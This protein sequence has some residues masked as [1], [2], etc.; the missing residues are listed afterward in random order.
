MRTSDARRGMVLVVV[1]WTIALLAGLAMAA[2]TTFRGFAGIVGVDRDRI[3]ADALLTAGVERVAGLLAASPNQAVDGEEL[4]ITLSAGSVRA[5][6]RDEGGR[7]DIGKAPAEVLI[8]LLSFAGAANAQNIA[9]DIMEWREPNAAAGPC[10]HCRHCRHCRRAAATHRQFG[11][12]VYRHS[13]S[14]QYS[15][16]RS[17]TGGVVGAAD[18]GVRQ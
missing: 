6:L 14:S 5:R 9:R 4:T 18:H 13:A 1:L 15:Q 16:P 2:S 12:S 17:R 3:R 10:R 8:S 11:R 7:I